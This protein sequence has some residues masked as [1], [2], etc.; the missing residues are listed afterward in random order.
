M[1]QTDPDRFDVVIAGGGLAGL[2]LAR[3]LR[4]EIPE[5]RVCVVERQK[6]PLPAAAHKVGE[7]S[8]EL[9]SH[10][11]GVVLGLGDYL[12]REQ[13]VK[14]GLRFFPG[15]GHTHALQDR[16]EIGPPQLPKVPSFQ[17]DRGRLEND[18]R[19]MDEAD[20]V[21]LLEGFTVKDVELATGGA[22]HRVHIETLGGE[23]ARVLSARY[24]VDA[25]GR[26]A[27]LR[28]KLGLT[29]P[30]GHNANRSEERRVGKE[31]R[32]R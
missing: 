28:N 14:N 23:G 24:F 17:L 12:R 18:L 32:I 31:C 20:G 7:S 27:I 30:S 6:R 29:R 19:A 21:T 11:F 25:S 8:V 15:G 22:D 10:Y 3:Q 2:T 1:S 4:R 9:S 26:R 13:F 5:A 16:T